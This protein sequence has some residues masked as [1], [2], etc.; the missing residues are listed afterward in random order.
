[1]EYISLRLSDIED[2]PFPENLYVLF[3]ALDGFEKIF[4]FLGY[5]VP[6]EDMVCI[7]VN[8]KVKV[9]F[10]SDLSLCSLPESQGESTLACEETMV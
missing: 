6:R 1:L 10:N 5:F 4:Y 8:G 9:W 7:D 2:I 3:A